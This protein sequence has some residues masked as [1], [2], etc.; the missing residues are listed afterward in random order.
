MMKT[1]YEDAAE[2]I[3]SQILRGTYRE[4]DRLPSVRC[5]SGEL[6]VSVNTV[7]EAYWLLEKE[8][9][10][11]AHP[12]SG[13]YVKKRLPVCVSAPVD[14]AALNP[15]TLNLCQIYGVMQQSGGIDANMNIGISNID[16][17]LWPAGK[18]GTYYRDI[19]RHHDRYPFDYIMPPGHLPLRTQ[20]ARLSLSGG[21]NLSP[22]EIII[23]NGCHEAVFLALMSICRQGDTVAF[24][25]PI[26]F[27]ALN[28]LRA[29]ELKVIEI[30][31][32]PR[33]GMSLDTLRF[34]LENHPVKAVFSIP[35]F[36][37]PLGFVMPDE[38]KREMVR[39]L[40]RAGIPLIEDD[41]YGE[42]Y[43]RE[44]P[45]TLKSH[46]R[47]GN[48]I[49]C[50]SMSKT[51]APGL[52][53]GWIAPGRHYDRVCYLKNLLNI[54][55]SSV[56]QIVAARFLQEGGYD[57]H[58]RKVRSSIAA[59]AA[60]M[61]RDILDIFPDGTE[62]TDPQGGSLLWVTLPE[63]YDTSVLYREAMKEKILIA[64]GEMFSM[65]PQFCRSFRINAGS[66]DAAA[67]KTI[68]QLKKFILMQKPK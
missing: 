50:S 23:T 22:D 36:N 63:G 16:P 59:S 57:R 38:K 13:F 68:A 66:Y 2:K 56:N 58:M 3:R 33:E 29:M 10:I 26:Y 55:T 11:E 39:L 51:V 30:P 9:F 44:R 12:Q 7:K 54:S 52:R 1:L 35:N 18:L 20:I 31:S 62:I 24:E 19:A 40:D 21:M 28:L 15:Q 32:S 61:R 60:A 48:V 8:N 43:H 5:L 27:S 47:S 34:V 64:P 49:H 45:S 37:N 14:L 6:G 46:D 42:L 53:I 65:R 4:G 25:S 17:A 41:V 67:K